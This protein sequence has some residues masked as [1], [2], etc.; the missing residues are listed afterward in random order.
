MKNNKNAF[1]KPENE[2]PKVPTLLIGILILS[3]V[4]ITFAFNYKSSI[5]EYNHEYSHLSANLRTYILETIKYSNDSD[6]GNEKAFDH[7]LDTQN[8]FTDTLNKLEVGNPASGLPASSNENLVNLRAVISQWNEQQKN[9]KTIL[10]SEKVIRLTKEFVRAV[11]SV[12]PGVVSSSEQLISNIIEKQSDPNLIFVASHQLLVAQRIMTNMNLVAQQG[13]KT[14]TYIEALFE[15]TAAFRNVLES[16]L[17]GNN[18]KSIVKVRSKS[19]RDEIKEL[20]FAFETIEELIARVNESSIRLIQAHLATDKI[21]NNSDNLLASVNT[22]I[23]GYH[24]DTPESRNVTILIYSLQGISL[25][26][27]IA[28]ILSLN[29]KTRTQLVSEEETNKETIQAIIKLQNEIAPIANG[30]LTIQASV[31]PGIT[32]SIS[33]TMNIS[34]SSLRQLVRNIGIMTVQVSETAEETQATA[35]H[36]AKASDTQAQQLG[37]V[38]NSINKMVRSFQDVARQAEE[39]SQL[40]NK[41]VEM[42]EQGGQ[43]VRNTLKGMQT[44]TDDIYD[45][46]SRIKR[47]G[48]SSQEIGDIVELIND[49]ADQTNILALNAAI[50]ASVAGESGQNFTLVADEVQQLAERVTQATK[51]I[52]SLVNSIQLDTSQAVSSM[53]QSNT[54]VLH[55]SKLARTAGDSLLRIETVSAHLAEFINNVSKATVNLT[56]TSK[57]ISH[58]MNS[59]KKVTDHNLAGTKQ[60]ATLTG[61]LAELA[62]VQKETVK[63]FKL[64]E[65]VS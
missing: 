15:D 57:E 41:A 28:L 64:P 49:I 48:E 10:N 44:I 42:A 8:A 3:I 53:E 21:L 56:E 5:E 46:S 26:T 55:G 43:S 20:I 63:G 19:L 34:I 45:T 13:N 9:I 51:K 65:S 7:L 1:D 39:S 50:K 30:D 60:T 62:K 47:L 54:D 14:T 33:K 2:K 4:G 61:K 31:E 58:A 38:T 16:M 59:I 25:V 12:M 6:R 40:A 27:L 52:E 23:D 29:N 36:L 35:I 11:N 32:E 17:K 22:L 18:K 24:A 37:N